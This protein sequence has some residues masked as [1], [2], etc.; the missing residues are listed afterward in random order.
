MA[1]DICRSQP[2]GPLASRKLVQQSP[3]EQ[4]PARLWGWEQGRAWCSRGVAG[5][6]GEEHWD[7]VPDIPTC[8]QAQLMWA[9]ATQLRD[10]EARAQPTASFLKIQLGTRLALHRKS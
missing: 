8:R 9:Q 4:H 10:R 6:T 7:C 1:A 3:N 2:S 5:G